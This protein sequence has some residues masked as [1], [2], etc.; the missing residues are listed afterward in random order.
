MAEVILGH[1]YERSAGRLSREAHDR[2]L[3]ISLLLVAGELSSLRDDPRPGDR[4]FIGKQEFGSHFEAI[5][6]ELDRDLV[7]MVTEVDE[8]V[9]MLRCATG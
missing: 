1:G 7:R 3:A 6:T 9:G 4:A 5:A 2:D 8:P